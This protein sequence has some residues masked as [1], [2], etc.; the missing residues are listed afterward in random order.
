MMNTASEEMGQSSNDDECDFRGRTV[1]RIRME[2]S[3]LGM[4]HESRRDKIYLSQG[5]GPLARAL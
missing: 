3:R 2:A 1:M 5:G 4:S